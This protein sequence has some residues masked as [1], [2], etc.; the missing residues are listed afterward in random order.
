LAASIA[1]S[2]ALA[3][4]Y[5]ELVS[6]DDEP[7]RALGDWNFVLGLALG[8]RGEESMAYWSISPGAAQ[9]LARRLYVDRRL[10][11]ELAE[12]ILAI[13]LEDLDAR[14]DDALRHSRIDPPQGD[15]DA[16]PIFL[17]GTA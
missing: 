1:A 14:A 10:R 6:G 7:K 8:L 2:E 5:P 11:R 13:D 15:R 12:H 17:T 3:A 16:A 9:S 4:R